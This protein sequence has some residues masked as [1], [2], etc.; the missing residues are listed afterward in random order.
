MLR[1]SFF[2]DMRDY[3]PLRQKTLSVLGT[4]TARAVKVGLDEGADYARRNHRHKIRTGA[5][6]S[7]QNLRGE[8]L[9]V[10]ANGATG[11]LVNVTPYARFVEYGTKPHPIWPKEGHGFVGPL[12][13][14]QSRR[15][16]TDIGTHRIALRFM[17]G[18]RI[19]FARM[20][21]HPG[22][23]PYPFMYPAAT[24]IGV[25]IERET[26]NV[27]FVLAAALWE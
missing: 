3:W 7:A 20:V 1:T 22:G 6:T 12:Q 15:H 19:V 26:N 27:T 5:L 17:V 24:F 25:V 2:V 18:G 9:Q 4:G 14:G 11:Q 16:I 13:A 23:R 8:M 10:D 21:N